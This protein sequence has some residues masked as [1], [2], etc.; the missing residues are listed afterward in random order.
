MNSLPISDEEP[1]GIVK[2]QQNLLGYAQSLSG[3]IWSDYN[4]HDPGV[5]L[6]EQIA[7]AITEIEYR[8]ALPI[9]DRL[10]SVNLANESDSYH[11][12]PPDALF[13]MQAVTVDDYEAVLSSSDPRVERVLITPGE[14]E[15]S[16]LYHIFVVPGSQDVS[17]QAC[18]AVALAYKNIRNLCEDAEVTAA[19]AVPCTMALTLEHHRRALPEQIVAEAFARCRDLLIGRPL[20]G[21][22]LS[23]DEVFA[24]PV[25]LTPGWGAFGDRARNTSLLS[26]AVSQIPGV[27]QVAKLQLIECATS[28]IIPVSAI[29]AEQYYSLQLPDELTSISLFSRG[30]QS[31]VDMDGVKHYLSQCKRDYKPY[32]SPTFPIPENAETIDA[33]R[34][35]IAQELPVAYLAGS[36]IDPETLPSRRRTS[37]MQFRHYVNLLDTLLDNVEHSR[38][39]MPALYSDSME[40]ICTDEM[41]PMSNESDF[42]KTSVGKVLDPHTERKSRA[43]DRLLGMFGEQ[44]TQSSLKRFRDKADNADDMRV[45][46]GKKRFLRALPDIHGNRCALSGFCKKLDILLDLPEGH[47]DSLSPA[48]IVIEDILLRDSREFRAMELDLIFP[49]DTNRNDKTGYKTFV[50]ETIS[51]VSPAHIL[52]R[53]KW[54]PRVDFDALNELINTWKKQK[55][56]D[57]AAHIRNMLF[58]E[59]S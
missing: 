40:Y 58:S 8:A 3:N 47:V 14:G 16:G 33:E 20:P 38:A 53:V 10:V 35:A 55:S 18:T 1:P 27:L 21:T 17:E 31:V 25:R 44:F 13:R 7:Y 23:P 50:A 54:L 42:A 39:D 56:A 24:N 6:L 46:S 30:R 41:T 48:Y 12:T 5:M 45:L 36:Q 57:N 11:L 52:P 28:K 49:L 43:L 37:T 34:L 51:L 15:E 29:G 22:Q 9:T 59:N 2:L 19:K 32:Q 4:I 26:R